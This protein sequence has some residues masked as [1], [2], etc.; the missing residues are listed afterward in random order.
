MLETLPEEIKFHNPSV[1][2]AFICKDFEF[3]KEKRCGQKRNSGEDYII[4]PYHIASILTEMSMD[5]TTVIVGL[6]HGV[7]EDTD[8]TYEN[9][10]GF[11]REEIAN[12]ADGVTRLKKLSY[13][14]G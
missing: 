8:V 13:Q 6:L 10:R 12:L 4:H 7:V 2:E 14:T 3:T 11:L 9:V 1:D 5:P